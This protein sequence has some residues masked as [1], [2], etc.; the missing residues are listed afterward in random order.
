MAKKN[1]IASSIVRNKKPPR[2]E[3][4][5]SVRKSEEFWTGSRTIVEYLMAISF[6]ICSLPCK[7]IMGYLGE[8]SRWECYAPQGSRKDL[9]LFLNFVCS[10]R[11]SVYYSGISVCST[12]LY[13]LSNLYLKFQT[14]EYFKAIEKAHDRGNLNSPFLHPH[15]A[16]ETSRVGLYIIRY[17]KERCR[18]KKIQPDMIRS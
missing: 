16:E 17:I 15:Q 1:A 18:E 14:W 7:C 4:A 3:L 13:L 9:C 5:Y 2:T 8:N 10:I 11:F 12:N 6:C